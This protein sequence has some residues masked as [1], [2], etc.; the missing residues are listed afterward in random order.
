[1]RW[2]WCWGSR[3]RSGRVGV[4]ASRPLGHE[5]LVAARRPSST[6]TSI[7]GWVGL[8]LRH[9][10]PRAPAGPQPP[11]CGR[12][13]LRPV[14]PG[15]G[16]VQVGQRD[17]G[18]GGAD[19]VGSP[20]PPPPAEQATRPSTAGRV[21]DIGHTGQQVGPRRCSQQPTRRPPRRCR[22]GNRSRCLR[23]Q[24]ARRGPVRRADDA[25]ISASAWVM[26][27]SRPARGSGPGPWTGRRRR[28]AAGGRTR[29]RAGWPGP[30][31][32]R[33]ILPDQREGQVD[34]G[35]HAGGGD[36]LARRRPP[37]A[38]WRWR[39]RRRSC[40]V[41]VPVG[42]GVEPVEHAGGAEQQG[43]GAHRGRPRRVLVGGARPSRRAGRRS[44]AMRRV[45]DAAR[46]QQH[47]GRGHVGEACARRRSGAGR[48]RRRAGPAARRTST[49]SAPG[50]LVKTW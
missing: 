44:A 29:C 50:R 40:V 46:H 36:D 7:V 25:R 39:R 27:W 26:T 4:G 32:R 1:M 42:G 13:D 43:A 28:R 23:R 38:R 24:A 14:R 31:R 37:A 16:P 48:C 5:A 47:V 33:P 35:R 22:P 41:G 10:A 19:G 49:T 34:A 45:I 2:V 30:P 3:A 21:S 11:R 17:V 18:Q 12:G 8:E 9:Q 20:S 15:R 6:T